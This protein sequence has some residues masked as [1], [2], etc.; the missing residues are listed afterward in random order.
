MSRNQSRLLILSALLAVSQAG[1][2]ESPQAPSWTVTLEEPTGI[3]RR[4]V[5]ESGVN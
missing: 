5:Y 2:A 3:Y 1:A 4:N